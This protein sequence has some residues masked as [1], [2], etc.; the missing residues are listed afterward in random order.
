MIDR[1]VAWEP[2]DRYHTM[3]QARDALAEA[4]QRLDDC[5]RH[6]PAVVA[7]L[8]VER[9]V[10]PE[11]TPAEALGLARQVGDALCDAAEERD[12]GLCWKRQ[13]ETEQTTYS[14]DLY[15]G[16]AGIGLF[17]AALARETGDDRYAD[18]ARGAARWVAG[19]AWGRGRGQAWLHDG[20]AGVAYFLLRL[21]ELLDAPATSPQPSCG[22][23]GCGGRPPALSISC[24]AP[25]ARSSDR[26]RCTP[27]P[28]TTSCSRTHGQPG[29]Q[30]VATWRLAA[31]DGA[32]QS[33]LGKVPSAA[34]GGAV[35]PYL[36]LLHGAAGM[37]LALAQL[38]L[39]TADER[40][41]G[42][43][44]RGRPAPRRREHDR[45]RGPELAAAPRRC[46]AGPAGAL[47]R[48]RRIGQFLLALDR[49]VPD[50]RYR[51]AAAGAAR[52]VRA[53]KEP[54]SGICHGLSGVG[55][56]M[57]DAYQA[58]RR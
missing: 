18:T 56:P 43:G 57:L 9:P 5:P 6:A 34:P 20:E 13:F 16:A 38:G 53:V 14:P 26:W 11:L 40:Y 27:S 35:T 37:G 30:L 47:P 1:A 24:T 8:D 21:A 19:P 50:P 42:G 41:L 29:D 33:L 2:A 22:C 55:P 54:R 39:V 4:A 48:R 12:G 49:V 45:R 25:P 31:P 15:G 44:G 7:D 51:Q 58:A 32:G 17:L 23:G 3:R 36:G 52:T 28:S 46:E 10:N